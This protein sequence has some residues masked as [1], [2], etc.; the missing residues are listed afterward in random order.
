MRVQVL[1]RLLQIDE[2]WEGCLAG[3][4]GG[5]GG[6]ATESCDEPGA[7]AA[8]AGSGPMPD[9]L[10]VGSAIATESCKGIA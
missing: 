9:A 7:I 3:D 1:T 6:N 5:C 10:G 2:K 4:G 8:K